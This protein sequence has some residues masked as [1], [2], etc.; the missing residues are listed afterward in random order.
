[1]KKIIALLLL[2]PALAFAQ[3]SDQATTGGLSAQA[4]AAGLTAGASANGT[5]YS[6]AGANNGGTGNGSNQNLI[7]NSSGGGHTTIVSTPN[8]QGNA[9][10][11]SAS[12]DGCSNSQ[13]GG[14]AGWLIGANVVLSHDLMTCYGLR[15]YER[16]MQWAVNLPSEGQIANWKYPVATIDDPKHPENKTVAR[17]Y[18]YKGMSKEQGMDMAADELC[19]LGDRQRALMEK[20]GLCV[21]VKDIPTYDHTGWDSSARSF[22]RQYA[23]DHPEQNQP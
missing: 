2:L 4:A 5:G 19:L 21:N 23:K 7:L 14:A 17:V 22:D 18:E 3:Q 1:M 13:G 10:Y 12:P 15:I 16:T 20:R 11:G 9:F 6:A 8:V